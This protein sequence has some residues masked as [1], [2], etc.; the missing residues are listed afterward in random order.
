MLV[1]A[2]CTIYEADTYTK[3]TLRDVYWHDS[4][5]RTIIRG[6]IQVQ[7]SLLVYLYDD[8]YVPKAGDLIVRGSQDFSFDTQSQQAVSQSMK[9]FRAAY[10]GFA[11]V[12][13]VDNAMYGGL[14]HIELI[15]R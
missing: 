13:N 4:R 5:G 9:Q 6:G 15:A 14:P 11:V 3:H 7:D 8:A 2:D 1:N 10:P 12:K